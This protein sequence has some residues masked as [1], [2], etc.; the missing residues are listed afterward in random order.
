MAIV[1][2]EPV[3]I[4]RLVR[5]GDDVDVRAW[6]RIEDA[7]TYEETS[8]QSVYG[9]TVREFAIRYLPEL[10]AVA[11]ATSQG[12]GLDSYRIIDS[13]GREYE[14]TNVVALERRRYHRITAGRRLYYR[15]V[16]G[17]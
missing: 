6:A 5:D 17:G 7:G 9:I 1:L 8:G 11:E 4:R 2:D 13:Q 10:A 12:G 14:P 16:G 3:V 15:F